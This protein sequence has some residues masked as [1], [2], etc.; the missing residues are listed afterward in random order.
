MLLHVLLRSIFDRDIPLQSLRHAI[1]DWDL[2]TILRSVRRAIFD[3]DL[4]LVR[5]LSLSEFLSRLNAVFFGVSFGRCGV[6]NWLLSF[7]RGFLGR[8]LFRRLFLSLDAAR[9]DAVSFGLSFGCCR[10]L[11][12]L[13]TFGRRLF[14]MLL[15][16]F[17]W[18]PSL[19]DA[20]SFR[21]C[22]SSSDADAFVSPNA[23]ALTRTLLLFFGRGCFPRTRLFPRTRILT[24]EC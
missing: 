15:P 21:R 11:M 18:T 20:V 17:F 19:S 9:S 7:G 13:L 6:L 1:F 16:R 5:T 8:R 23:D 22:C 12:R 24:G 3:C 2:R 10:V 4:R 14:R